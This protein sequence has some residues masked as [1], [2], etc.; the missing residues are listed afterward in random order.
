M[1]INLI[2]QQDWDEALKKITD[3]LTQTSS[4]IEQAR[5]VKQLLLV[6]A[7]VYL[8]LGNTEKYNSDLTVYLKNF[9]KI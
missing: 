7:M 3:E 2:Q 8:E 5:N 1:I 4:N 6:R 9:K